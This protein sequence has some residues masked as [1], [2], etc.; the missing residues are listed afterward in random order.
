MVHI[1][2]IEEN[3]AKTKELVAVAHNMDMSIEAE[4]GSIGGEE[5]GVIGR[6]ECADPDECKA[7]AESWCRYDLQQ[8]SVTF[9]E[10]IL[11]TGKDL[12]LKLLM[13]FSRRQELCH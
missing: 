2:Q 4:V 1:I 13:Q 6:G 11:K 8:V 3:I 10:N 7:V 9:M 12:V 5:D